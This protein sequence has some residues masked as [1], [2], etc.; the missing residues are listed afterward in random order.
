MKIDGQF[1]IYR[2][3][4]FLPNHFIIKSSFEQLGPEFKQTLYI[5]FTNLLLLNVT[6]FN[7]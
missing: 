7:V 6:Y 1:S 4:K 5:N 2:K 3:N